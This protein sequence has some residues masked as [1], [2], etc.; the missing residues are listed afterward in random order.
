MTGQ[1]SHLVFHVQVQFPTPSRNRDIATRSFRTVQVGV[2]V[3]D[4]QK[5]LVRVSVGKEIKTKAS[6]HDAGRRTVVLHV[7]ERRR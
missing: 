5:Y 4:R 6:I 2:S 1:L 3:A 7:F